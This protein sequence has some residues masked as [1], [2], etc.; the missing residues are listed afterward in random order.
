[1]CL[2]AIYWARL[3]KL[4]FGNSRQDAAQIGF[5]DESIYQQVA[6]PPDART[7]RCERLLPAQA[8][9]AFADWKAKADKIPY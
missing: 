6:L 9:V 3:K 7:L 8:L 2:S 4:Y 1:M 5:D